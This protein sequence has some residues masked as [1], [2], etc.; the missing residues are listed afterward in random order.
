MA[1]PFSAQPPAERPH[2][3]CIR[4]CGRS[5]G[6]CGRLTSAVVFPARTTYAMAHRQ[7]TLQLTRRVGDGE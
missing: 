4:H 3:F 5:A 1:T 2:H 7:G 6:G